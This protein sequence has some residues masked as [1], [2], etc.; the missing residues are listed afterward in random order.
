MT[1][2]QAQ[3]NDL[4][5][6]NHISVKSKKNWGYPDEWIDKWKPDLTIEER[7]LV[8]KT[9]TVGVVEGNVVGFCVV[10]EEEENYEILH[11]WLLP[12]FIGKGFGSQLLE[13]GLQQIISEEKPILV[14]A[15]PNAEAFY[16]RQGFVTFDKSESYPPGRFLP[17]MKKT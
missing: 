7:D 3:P 17:V 11:L 9:I 5:L 8:E 1:F 15:D 13:A 10:K 14:E 12:E 16:R 2:R 6:L 4:P